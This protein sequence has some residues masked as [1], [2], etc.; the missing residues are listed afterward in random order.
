MYINIDYY[1]VS[2]NVFVCSS[3]LLQLSHAVDCLLHYLAL[4]HSLTGSTLVLRLSTVVSQGM[5]LYQW[6]QGSIWHQDSGTEQ[7]LSVNVSCMY[8]HIAI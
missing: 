4:C 6:D 5:R 8:V 2:V 7:H 3:P 1:F